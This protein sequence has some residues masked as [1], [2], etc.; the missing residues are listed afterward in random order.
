MPS[1]AK[2]RS[3]A[4]EKSVVPLSSTRRLEPSAS[5]ACPP[6]KP[7]RDG[8]P[9][10][11]TECEVSGDGRTPGA[12]LS[13]EELASGDALARVR[14]TAMFRFRKAMNGRDVGIDDVF[15]EEARKEL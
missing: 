1:A 13:G 15:E 6:S 3:N 9:V 14:P 12:A 8:A 10:E 11:V 4:P 5:P 2:Y 7:S